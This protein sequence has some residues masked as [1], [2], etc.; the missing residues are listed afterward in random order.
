MGAKGTSTT[1]STLPWIAA[2]LDAAEVEMGSDTNRFQKS[3]FKKYHKRCM[4]QMHF[5]EQI[6]IA[7]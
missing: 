1:I 3:Y 6:E 4:H 2:L 5:T 7:N